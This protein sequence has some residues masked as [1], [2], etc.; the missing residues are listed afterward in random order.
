MAEYNMQYYYR[1]FSLKSFDTIY[2][3]AYRSFA[4]YMTL[5]AAAIAHN[6]TVAKDDLF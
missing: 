4:D 6:N 3:K 1:W 5:A 2:S